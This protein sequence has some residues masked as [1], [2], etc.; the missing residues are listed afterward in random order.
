LI[1]CTL[2]AGLM[3]IAAGL[4]RLG[5]L[6]K[7]IPQPVVTG[8]TAGIAVSIFSNQIKDLLG[9]SMGA[10]PASSR[11][12]GSVRGARRGL[13]ASRGRDR[14]GLSLAL[15]SGAA[16][17]APGLAAFPDRG[18]GGRGGAA[19][20]SRCPRD[21]RDRLRRHPRPRCPRSRSLTSAS[22]GRCEMFPSAFTIAFLAGPRVAALGRGR[23]GYDGGRH[24]SNGELVAQASR[25][26]GSALFG[27]L[28]ATGAIARTA[29][30]IR[31]GGR[32][33]SPG[34]R[35]PLFLLA[36]MLLLR[37]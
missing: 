35:T 33:R 9:S 12:A 32:T 6:M 25:T 29:V 11:R 2:L 26:S 15:S 14:R 8:F 36:F 31:S 19:R 18:G 20:C 23:D 37:R 17:L 4:L 7:Y 5:A 24:R 28:P 1:L 3:L 22:S 21:H 27:G 16:A 10:V 30:N 13:Y 34:S